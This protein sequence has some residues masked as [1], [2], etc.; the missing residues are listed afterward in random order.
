V[1]SDVW[2]IAY[3]RMSILAGVDVTVI[4]ISVH[5]DRGYDSKT[6]HERLQD[7]V[8]RDPDIARRRTG[9]SCAA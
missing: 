8:T 1:E 5:L 2:E 9:G 6:T 4:R 3:L 7:R